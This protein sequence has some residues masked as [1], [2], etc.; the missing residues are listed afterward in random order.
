MSNLER[1]G[2][3]Q[4]LANTYLKLEILSRSMKC[5]S[6]KT[7]FFLLLREINI[8]CFENSNEQHM[9][10]LSVKNAKIFNC[11]SKW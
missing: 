3:F 6:I 2:Q 1:I 9:F 8:L 11:H 10:I 5:V 7:S 4:N